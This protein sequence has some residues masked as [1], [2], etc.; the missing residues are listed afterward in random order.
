MKH[1][2][3]FFLIATV[4]MLLSH[5]G[6]GATCYYEGWDGGSLAGWTANTVQTIVELRTTGGN[7]D[8]YVYTYME[9]AGGTWDAGA[10]STLPEVTG[11]YIAGRI[12]R[13]SFDIQFIAGD[14][15][16]LWF[17]VRYMDATYNGW[18]FPLTNVFPLGTW[19]SYTIDFDPTWS[20]AE[21]M[22][23]GWIQESTSPSFSTT[24]SDVYTAEVRISGEGDIEAGIDN[25]H[26]YCGPLIVPFDI[27]PTSCPNPLNVKPFNRQKGGPPNSVLPVAILGTED[28]DVSSID[29][30]SILLENVPPLRHS[31]EDVATP[32]DDP[33]D[34]ACT[35]EGPDGNLDLTLKFRKADIVYALGT[36]M[37]GQEVPLTITGLL[38][39]GTEF[40]GT[41]CVLIRGDRC[42]DLIPQSFTLLGPPMVV[43]GEAL[44]SR[45]GA[46]VENT[47]HVDAGDF[48]VG[49]YISSDPEITIADQLLIGGRE[50]ISSVAAGDAVPVPI[51][52]SMTVPPG[53]PLGTA[54]IGV[55][56]DE[57]DDV[58]EC[59]EANNT[60]AIRVIVNSPGSMGSDAGQPFVL[61]NNYPNPFNPSTEISF[62]IPAASHVKLEVYNIMGQRVTTLVDGQL[63]AGTHTVQWNASETASGAYFYRL[64]ADDYVGARKMLLLK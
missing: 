4:I 50:Y 60:S 42:P 53:W 25:F 13:V 49:F 14:F 26:L 58:Y 62:S 38:L 5:V 12:Y 2:R 33:T 24:M 34:C 30:S 41:D 31:Y 64:Q 57:F 48:F 39:D 54:W 63:E 8:G 35:S 9:N 7:P 18:K 32:V 10:L 36:V 51:N 20:D 6:R 61:G 1:L 29:L 11:D 46:T 43:P 3:L 17:R 21:A 40:E 23:A 19:I 52:G 44:Q 27:K 15:G 16:D 22:A 45:I 59:D 37:D 28:F 47:G 56:M 55:V